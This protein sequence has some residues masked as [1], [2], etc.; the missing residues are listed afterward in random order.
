MLPGGILAG[1]A[2]LSGGAAIL[3]MALVVLAGLSAEGARGR[4]L[5]L[6]AATCAV[7]SAPMA[8]DA[9]RARAMAPGAGMVFAG[10]TL[11]LAAA[12][13]CLWR[14]RGVPGAGLPARTG[15]VASAASWTVLFLLW[16][17][18]A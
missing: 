1:A 16:S 9:A 4:T 14:L 7:A 13:W 15:M 12:I 10:A 17:G 11:L 2:V 18:I 3:C 5:A 6:L 8:L